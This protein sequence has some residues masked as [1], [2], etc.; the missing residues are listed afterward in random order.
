[1]I[2]LL[3]GCAVGPDFERPDAPKTSNYDSDALPVKTEAADNTNGASQAF[4]NGEDI[5]AEWW[6]LY[7]SEPL[8]QLIKQA[9]KANP[10]L[11]AAQAALREAQE[12][13]AAGSGYLFPT[14]SGQFD[15]TRQKTSGAAFGGS[16]PGFLYTLH[17]A[18]VS[19]SY[20][21]D[22]FGGTR[23]AIEELEASTDYQRFQLEAA[24]LSLTSNVVTTAINEASLRG[25]IAATKQILAEEDKQLEVT[26]NQ[27]D[28][29]AIN[30]APVLALK[31]TREQTRATLPVL[32]KQLSQTRHLLSV[33]VGQLPSKAPEATFDLTKLNLPETLP[34]TLP[35]Q[36]VEQRP[37][38]RA[39]EANLHAASA[40]IG[41]AIANRLPS[42]TL[43][44]DIG[45]EA[46]NLGK[47]FTPGTGIWSAGFSVAQTIFDAGTLEHKEGS[48]EAAYD[49]AAA[50]YR[51]TV[52]G[53][54]QD[55][56]DVLRALQSDAQT[57][58]ADVEAE[59]VAAD[60]L[61]L[62]KQQFDAGSASYLDVLSAE[63]TEQKAKLAV[64]QAE[65]QRFADTAALFQALGGGWWNRTS[66]KMDIS[67]VE[68]K[69]Q[70]PAGPDSSANGE[71]N[72]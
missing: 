59:K 30:K 49:V 52:L 18:T 57:L 33:L 43:S 5:P 31:A 26:Q 28:A 10:D 65:A 46:N 21:L 38:V 29:G 50:Q 48:A 44:A 42:F 16:F 66:N 61:A 6:T 70:P 27:L 4:A 9:L 55:V 11:K 40:A 32:E 19:V 15:T 1:L 34:V 39:A 51:K 69:S 35:S 72:D 23:R 60:S 2:A 22:L 56:A 71:K 45:S 64:V 3:A 62:F 24:Y 41:V 14:V 67:S 47:L 12:D 68:D 13:Y 63:Q 58:K 20:G 17:T 8:N 7:H 25:Q 37:D 54:F 53:A 36:L